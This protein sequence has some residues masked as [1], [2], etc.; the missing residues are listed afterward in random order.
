MPE[1]TYEITLGGAGN[2]IRVRIVTAKGQVVDFL[3][4]YETTVEGK[5]TPV[6]RYDGSHGRG[7]RDTL[8]R[9]GETIRKDWFPEHMTLGESLT[10][11]RRQLEANWVRYR[12]EFLERR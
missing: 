6:M 8:D 11:A 5:R 1:R 4:Q 9:R 10:E 12:D 3:A 7:H 2:Y